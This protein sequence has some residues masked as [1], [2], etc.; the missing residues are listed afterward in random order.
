MVY[1]SSN[2]GINHDIP[3]LRFKGPLRILETLEG[4]HTLRDRLPSPYV[5]V[6]GR[7]VTGLVTSNF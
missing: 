2:P 3:K 1:S 5:L 7:G 4:H 6:V